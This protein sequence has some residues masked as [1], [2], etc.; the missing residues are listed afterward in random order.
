MILSW[1]E[2]LLIAAAISLD[3]FAVI[4]VQGAK[5]PKINPKSLALIVLLAAGWQTGAL[6]V[7]RYF[8]HLLFSIDNRPNSERAVQLIAASVFIILGIRMVWKSTRD[9]MVEE[10]RQ[11]RISYVT[12]VKLLAGITLYTLL[13]GFA[14]GFLSAELQLVLPMIAICT[15]AAVAIGVFVGYRFGA[16]F[17]SKCYL[18]GGMMLLAVSADVVVRYV[19]VE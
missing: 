7:G 13:T 9:D 16:N 8:G 10:S 2:F 12:V 17:K 3:V 15:A 11:D 6:Y 5:L 4:A 18:A 14:V 1:I 19:I